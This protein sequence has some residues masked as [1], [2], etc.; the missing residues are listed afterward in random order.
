MKQC[1]VKNT[2]QTINIKNISPRRETGNN[3]SILLTELRKLAQIKH[4]F[5][6]FDKQVFFYFKNKFVGLYLLYF[7]IFS[8]YLMITN[9]HLIT[10]KMPKDVPLQVFVSLMEFHF[11]MSLCFTNV[12]SCTA[13][14]Q[15]FTDTFRMIQVLG[16]CNQNSSKV[17]LFF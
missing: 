13:S 10:Y 9:K 12:R 1:N 5:I 14:I 17:F 16:L 11:Y 6:T 2:K 15:K 3:K 7:E 8:S 4:W